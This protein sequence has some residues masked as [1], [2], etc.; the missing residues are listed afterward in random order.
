[1]V[2]NNLSMLKIYYTKVQRK[3][4]NQ[5]AGSVTVQFTVMNGNKRLFPVNWSVMYEHLTGFNTFTVI[6][7]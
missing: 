7:R 3:P 1:M 4:G 5:I 6:I 2:I